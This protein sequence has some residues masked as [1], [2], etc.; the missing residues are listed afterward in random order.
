M[1]LGLDNI[2]FQATWACDII[3][4]YSIIIFFLKFKVVYITHVWT[5]EYR[6][7]LCYSNQ[8][9]PSKQDRQDVHHKIHKL[10]WSAAPHR[11]L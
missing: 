8:H 3:Y 10:H 6:Y 1:I 9:R 7:G 5:F 4:M 2:F 11:R